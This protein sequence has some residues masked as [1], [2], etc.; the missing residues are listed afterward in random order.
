MR[1]YIA[2]DFILVLHGA[3]LFLCRQVVYSSF[4]MCSCLTRGFVGNSGVVVFFF[5]FSVFLLLTT[6]EFQ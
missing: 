2:L 5:S 3:S 4:L 6:Y 1:D